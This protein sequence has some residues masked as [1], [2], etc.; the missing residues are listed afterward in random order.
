VLVPADSADWRSTLVAEFH[1]HGASPFFPRRA[2][3]DGRF[4]LIHNLRAGELSASPSV[5]GDRA[6]VSA[7]RLDAD[8]PARQAM[9]RLKN[10]PEWE[11][12]DLKQDPHE[13]VELS[14][15]PTRTAQM[16]R[17]KRALRDWQNRT[18][19]PFTDAAF[20]AKVERTYRKSPR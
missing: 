14:N 9:E 17:L 8:H 11:F 10:P 20:R 6:H 19:D 18:G 16:R 4:K 5:D 2:I 7:Q 15:D 12:Y 1:F 13:F 3:T